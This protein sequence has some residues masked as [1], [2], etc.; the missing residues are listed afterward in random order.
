MKEGKDLSEIVIPDNLTHTLKHKHLFYWDDS[1]Q[2]DKNRI[3]VFTT[4]NNLDILNEN[5]DWFG[6]GTFKIS[7][8]QVPLN[9]IYL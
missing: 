2:K 5:L 4:Q 6:D 1:G 7:P 8:T 9:L 3:I